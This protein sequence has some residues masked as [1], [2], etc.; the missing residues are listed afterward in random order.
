MPNDSSRQKPMPPLPQ[1]ILRSSV[2]I[3]SI[4][5]ELN[6]KMMASHPLRKRQPESKSQSFSRQ[7]ICTRVYL[8]IPPTMNLP[9]SSLKTASKVPLSWPWSKDASTLNFTNPTR[10]GSR[11][12]FFIASLGEQ[13]GHEPY[14]SPIDPVQINVI[15]LAVPIVR[16][17][18]KN[19]NTSR[20]SA[21][22][23]NRIPTY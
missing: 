15:T 7:D 18:F 11:T 4:L 16:H 17:T 13:A 19:G 3:T 10:D 9:L 6:D 22:S 21:N 5:S 8:L 14:W 12:L 23:A 1:N 20:A 2:L